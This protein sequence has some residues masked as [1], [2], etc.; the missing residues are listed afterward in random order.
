MIKVVFLLWQF[1]FQ[2]IDI[3]LTENE[4]YISRDTI[5]YK[6]YSSYEEFQSKELESENDQIILV[7]FW[8]TWCAPCVK[9]LPFFEAFNAQTND[10][11]VILVSLDFVEQLETRFKPFVHKKGLKSE[12]IVLDD[13]DANK[14]IDMVDPSWSGTIP[15]TLVIKGKERSFTDREFHSTQEIE[16]FIN[17]VNKH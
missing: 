9:E 17:Q 8:A 6:I 14:W 7:N 4:V 1:F 2:N 11:R 3:P 10:V 5:D 16:E 15:A 13:M 12:L